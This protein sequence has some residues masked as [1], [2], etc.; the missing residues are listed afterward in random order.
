MKFNNVSKSLLQMYI[1]KTARC[2]QMNI[3]VPPKKPKIKDKKKNK[4][5]DMFTVITKELSF[6]EI[7]SPNT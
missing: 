3:R 2:G 1:C 6:V 4:N 5:S 7:G